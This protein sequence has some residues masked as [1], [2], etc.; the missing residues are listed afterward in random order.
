MKK[1]I[2][3]FILIGIA[4]V[5]LTACTEDLPY[6]EEEDAP[7]AVTSVDKTGTDG[8]VDTYKISFSDGSTT[9]FTVTNVID[10]E[11]GETGETGTSITS[12]EK[13]GTEGV[14]DTYTISFSDGSATT[15]TLTNGV[16]GEQGISVVSIEKTGTDGVVDTYTI[17]FSDGTTTTFI[18]TNGEDGATG[19]IGET[20]KSG[21]S[22]TSI[23]KSGTEGLTDTYTIY[24]SDG[25]TTTFT[26]TN[27]EDGDTPYIGENGNWWI[28]END[29]GVLADYS[30][31]NRLISDGLIYSVATVGGKSGM[32]VCDY[33]GTDTNV[34]IPN[35][36]GSIP[37]IGIYKDA[38]ISNTQITTISLSENIL[39]LESDVFGGCTSLNYV[40]FNNCKLTELPE[41]AFFNTA[42]SEIEIPNSVIKIGD[43]C[44]NYT[45]L[46]KINYENITYYGESSL[47][48]YMG[49]YIYL[50]DKVEYV[51][52]NAFEYT[53][54]YTQHDGIPENWSGSIDGQNDEDNMLVMKNCSKNDEYIYSKDVAG[55]TIYKY[56]GDESRLEIPSTIDD[57]PVTKIGYGF[58]SYNLEYADYIKNEVELDYNEQIDLF[59]QLQE[60]KIP[61]TV[62]S[63]D[64]MSFYCF[65][66]MIYIPSSVEKMW[67]G[68]GYNDI[69]YGTSYLAFENETCPI[70]KEY[71]VDDDSSDDET[72]DWLEEIAVQLR[73]GYDID[74]TKLEYNQE[75]QTYYYNEGDNY[76]LFAIMNLKLECLEISDKFNEKPITFIRPYAISNLYNLKSI[77]IKDGVD[78]IKSYGISNLNLNY[79]GISDSVSIIN[80]NGIN[81]DC[82]YYYIK[83]NNKP[84]EWDSYWC[85]SEDVNEIYGVN[86]DNLA[87]NEDFF[88]LKEDSKIALIR[89][90]GTSNIINIPESIDEIEVYKIKTNFLET[91]YFDVYIPI[92][93]QIIEDKAF[94]ATYYYSSNMYCAAESKPEN[95][96]DNW[97]YNT[98]ANNSNSYVNKNWS[99]VSEN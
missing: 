63:L 69:S 32:M 54:V 99:Y 94:V 77:I 31:D 60:V 40:D 43:N 5:C 86:V 39:W 18:I 10:G 89:Y 48:T 44:F 78:K 30:Q 4:V 46:T 79:I 53:Y 74:Y 92:N 91:K 37:V 51:G 15:F 59:M 56:L 83:F 90:L 2:K 17:N 62:T 80:A 38:F 49:D 42:I 22:V 7:I 3:V 52:E 93:I 9:T 64:Y 98:Y 66:T 70:M 88:Y 25:T 36:I 20:G 72:A 19:E 34:N 75:E 67:Y 26:L 82:E 57:S 55:V 12:I 28:D 41:E 23:E 14:I 47:S 8:I 81:I 65:G 95:W 84:S 33:T 68:V 35:F 6:V 87:Y 85:G 71:F 61:N 45:P 16:D 27:G 76:S 97:Y 21:V 58:N 96:D 29:T 11:K 73:I 24:F 13:T 1:F 50:S